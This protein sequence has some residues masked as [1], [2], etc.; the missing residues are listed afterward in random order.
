MKLQ[1]VVCAL[2]AAATILTNECRADLNGSDDFND[3]SKDTNRWGA[4]FVVSGAGLL[5]ETNQRLE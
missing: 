1:Y 2:S 5:T 4:D 3:N